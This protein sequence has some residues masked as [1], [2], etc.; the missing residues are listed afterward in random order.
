MSFQTVDI[1]ICQRYIR[2]N[3]LSCQHSDKPSL[4]SIIV[5][6]LQSTAKWECLCA[7][8]FCGCAVL[9]FREHCSPGLYNL[10][11][12]PKWEWDLYQVALPCQPADST[13]CQSY[14]INISLPGGIYLYYLAVPCQPVHSTT[15]ESYVIYNP[16]PDGIYL[17]YLAVPCQPVDNTTYRS[18]VIQNP[19]AD[20]SV[21]V[22]VTMAG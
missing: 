4:V 6:K 10:Q 18:F 17:Y 8:L 7:F 14:V 12:T 15:Y 19:L 3:P 2:H 1:I 11:S 20:G 21:P 16:L 13:T 5:I 22:Y 9:T